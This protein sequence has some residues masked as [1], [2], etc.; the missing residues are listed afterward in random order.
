[1]RLERAD[2]VRDR[3]EVVDRAV[4]LP[5]VETEGRHPD[6]Q[7]GTDGDRPAEKRVQPIGLDPRS[8]RSE[9]R[10]TQRAV[11]H[12]L[13]EVAAVSLDDVTPDAVAAMHQRPA[14]DEIVDPRRAGLQRRRRLDRAGSS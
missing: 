4:Q 3:A 7:P 13:D 14:A 6:A 1:V 8:F 10:W 9:Q 12:E 2:R 11:G 5:V